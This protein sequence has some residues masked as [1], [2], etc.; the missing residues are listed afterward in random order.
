MRWRCFVGCISVRAVAKLAQIIECAPQHFSVARY[1]A[2]AG[3]KRIT[4]FEQ[5]LFLKSQSAFNVD[6]ALLV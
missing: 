2:A 6:K 5:S 3:R 1:F 4:Q